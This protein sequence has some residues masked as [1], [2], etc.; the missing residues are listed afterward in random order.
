MEE[1]KKENKVLDFFIK[2]L[3]G[4]AYLPH[5]LSVQ[6]LALSAHYL[7]KAIMASASLWLKSLVALKV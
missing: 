7:Q 3:N 4:M 5:L 6:S 2:T 1:T